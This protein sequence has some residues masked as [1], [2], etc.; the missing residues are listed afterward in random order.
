MATQLLG[1]MAVEIFTA[2]CRITGNHRT[3]YVHIREVLNE[4]K[5]SY[6]DLEGVN[7][8]YLQDAHKQPVQS[9]EARLDKGS[10]ILA[11]PH[12]IKGHTEIIKRRKMIEYTG[13]TEDRL[14][15]AAPPFQVSGNLKMPRGFDV[16]DALNR[17]EE[18][19]ITLTEAAVHYLP[20]PSVSFTVQ[21]VVLNREHIQM[22]CAGFREEEEE[23]QG[24]PHLPSG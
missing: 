12:H 2:Q 14:L 4:S 11:V 8:N 21:E 7:L 20:R 22:V 23:V 1:E 16:R 17:M 18:T 5:E 24:L 15:I 19:F 3:R 10:I 13:R 6:L 9:M